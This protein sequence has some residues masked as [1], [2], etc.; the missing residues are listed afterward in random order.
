MPSIKRI[1]HPY[2]TWEEN[3]Y[4]MWG[5]VIDRELYLQKAIE[6]VGDYKLY[7]FWML[8]VVEQWQH[9]CEHNLSDL[10]QNRRA[11]VGQAACAL[12]SQCPE[13]IVRVAW[14]HLTE[15]QQTLANKEADKAIKVWEEKHLGGINAQEEFRF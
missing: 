7:G 15:L 2:W 9:S 1:Y 6:F 4:N 12:A 8:K 13:D 14:G 5:S 3:N 11:W 10:S